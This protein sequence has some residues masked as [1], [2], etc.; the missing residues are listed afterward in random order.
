MEILALE[1]HDSLKKKHIGVNWYA[2]STYGQI[3]NMH[4]V[5]ST[6]SNIREKDGK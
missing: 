5:S 2:F 3:I 6:M 4:C 1:L